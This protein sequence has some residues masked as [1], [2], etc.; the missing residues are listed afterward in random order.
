MKAF[1][2]LMFLI[3]T[4]FGLHLTAVEALLCIMSILF[5]YRVASR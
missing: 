5:V 1:L 4:I 2:V 3:V